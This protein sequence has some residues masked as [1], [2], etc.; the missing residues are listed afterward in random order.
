MIQLSPNFHLD[1]FTHSQTAQRRG[2]DN[3]PPPNV[4]ANLKHTA[5][6][7]ELVRAALKAPILVSSGYRSPELNVAVGGSATSQHTR[8]EAVDFTAPSFGTPREIVEAIR[9]TSIP[10]DQLILEFDRWVHISFTIRPPRRQALVI[11][12][13]GTRAYA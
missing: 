4:V 11:D 7:M 5:Q 3:D 9:K 10:Y 13:A 8:G 1:E 6:M 2:I 12:R